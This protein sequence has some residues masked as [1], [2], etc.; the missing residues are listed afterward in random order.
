MT[1]WGVRWLTRLERHEIVVH[2]ITGASL[3]GVLVGVYSDCIVLTHGA[4]LG[5]DTTESVDG[6]IVVPREK[7]G[8]IQKLPGSAE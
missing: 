3:R 7:V 2:T 8:W 6:D 5:T 1:M 4:W